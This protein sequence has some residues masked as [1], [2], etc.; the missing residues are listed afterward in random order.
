MKRFLSYSYLVIKI[1]GATM[2]PSVYLFPFAFHQTG[3]V[4]SIIFL[5]VFCVLFIAVSTLQVESLAIANYLKNEKDPLTIVM[6]VQENLY[7]VQG[8]D[9]DNA[10]VYGDGKVDIPTESQDNLY[11]NKKYE[12]SETIDYILKPTDNEEE[13]EEFKNSKHH[14]TIMKFFICLF[15]Y[16]S[17]A[18]MLCFTS[19]TIFVYIN[20][21]AFKT[22][23]INS[24]VTQ[25]YNLIIIAIVA[26]TSSLFSQIKILILMKILN[27]VSII[28]IIVYFIAL[29]FSVSQTNIISRFQVDLVDI[30]NINRFNS[31]AGVCFFSFSIFPYIPSLIEDFSYQRKFNISISFGMILSGIFMMIFS[32]ISVLIFSNVISCDRNIFPSGLKVNLLENLVVIKG[33]GDILAITQFLNVFQIGFYINRLKSLKID[34]IPEFIQNYSNQ[35]NSGIIP[36]QRRTCDFIIVYISTLVL[37]VPPSLLCISELNI[38]IKYP[39]VI[40]GYPMLGYIFIVLIK[41]ARK[42]LPEISKDKMNTSFMRSTKTF[43]FFYIFFLVA[44]AF[45][46]ISL[47][48][49]NNIHCIAE[50]SISDLFNGKY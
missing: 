33:V 44:L 23:T 32:I 47:F 45:S 18:M 34:F 40:L 13:G 21:S 36:R 29:V 37:M 1:L 22:S 8:N 15:Y 11:I 31:L 6:T 30:A 7:S 49:G 17:I 25:G 12:L 20:R 4:L 41:Y 14:P 48:K 27:V 38:I 2:F 9:K 10:S 42:R 3:L 16:I 35:T 50:Y 28:N 19:D 46:C 39:M 5:L 24:D 26:A 43:L